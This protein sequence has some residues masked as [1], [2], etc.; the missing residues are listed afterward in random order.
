MKKLYPL[1]VFLFSLVTTAFSQNL[2]S[3]DTGKYAI[4]LPDYWK[5]G[6]KIWNILS[7]KLPTVSPE[8]ANKDLCGDKCK[9]AY[10]VVLYLTEPYIYNYS[11]NHIYATKNTETLD[12]V[13]SYVFECSLLLLDH[14]ENIITRFI[15]VDTDETW[16]VSRR[17]EL[18]VYKPVQAQRLVLL[19]N[20]TSMT[21][22]INNNEV[23]H[24]RTGT[25]GITPYA[26]INNNQEKL[27]PTIKELYA[28]IDSKISAW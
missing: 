12:F 21:N 15:L 3:V 11:F 13:T 4:E 20:S 19:N 16:K 22:T 8:L 17:A 14:Q 1:A 9:P 26:Y 23:T 25:A 5:P 18:P 10:K 6:N 27:A 7:D 2:S 28:I 24:G